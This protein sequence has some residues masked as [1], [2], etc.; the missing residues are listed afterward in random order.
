MSERLIN[1]DEI[2]DIYDGQIYNRLKQEFEN[3]F[4]CGSIFSLSINTDGISFA[5]GT[6]LQVWPIYLII[7]E[8]PISDRF[9]YENMVIA[10]I[11]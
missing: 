9:C 10:G 7:N 2:V 8:I 5:N 6:D 11:K 4:N 3:G 1:Q